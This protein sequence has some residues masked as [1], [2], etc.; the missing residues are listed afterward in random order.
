MQRIVVVGAS[1][2]GLQAVQT[3]RRADFAG[4]ITLVG[5]EPDL[6]YDRPPLSKG[7]LSGDVDDDRVRLRAAADPD[8][9]G[10]EWRLSTR[11]T[12]LDLDR[13]VVQT[14]DDELAFDG[15]VIATGARARRLPASELEGVH[16]LRTIND[17]RA[18]RDRLAAVPERLVVIGAGFIGAEVAATARSLGVDVTMIEAAEAPLTRVL[19]VEAGM[20]VAALHRD[21]G[22][23]VRL[24][25]GVRALH[26]DGA[27][28]GVE[29]VDGSMIDTD[30][31]VVGIGVIPNTE[32]LE[33]TG[34][35]IDDGVV[36]DATC[37]AAPGVVAAG[38]VARWPNPRYEGTRRVEQWD[39]AVDQ[40]AHAARRLL[41]WGAGEDGE[42]FDPVPWF[43]SDQ[44]D[45]KLQLA[46]V[47]TRSAALVH[48]S[49]ADRQ[50]VQV[51]LDAEGVPSGALAWNRPR[52]AI[53]AR[54]L[55]AAG[56]TAADLEEALA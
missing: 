16:V 11:A 22:V 3:L 31:V 47:P 10:I 51:F 7:F 27:V 28:S 4:D 52:H 25:A 8:A 12:G 5:E 55:L 42:A 21:H 9:L 36:C 30:M 38:D 43:W 24:G 56:V 45:R 17:A 18:I 39:N 32:W 49:V 48:G 14:A 15:L 34:L 13:R 33:S 46:G 50:F 53:K 41:A 20:E 26:G 54:Q 44:Y 35:E 37:L 40:G 23:D 29:L 1:L 6:P 2:A 19:G